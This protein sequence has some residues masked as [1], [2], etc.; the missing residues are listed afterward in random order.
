MVVKTD[1]GREIRGAR[2]AEDTYSLQMTDT[3]G[4]LLLLDKAHILD[5]R[6][7]FKSLMPDDFAKRLS[8]PEIQNIVAY[9]E[10]PERARSC[11]DD[12]SRYSRRPD[13]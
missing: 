6:Y 7:E 8:Q 12:P 10:D 4:K 2:R 9:S 11:Q 1:D 13:L 3:A 5:E